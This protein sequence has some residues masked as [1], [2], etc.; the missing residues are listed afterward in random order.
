MSEYMLPMSTESPFADPD[1]E[2]Q[3]QS[4]APKTPGWYP[5]VMDFDGRWEYYVVQ[6]I[7]GEDRHHADFYDPRPVKFL[8]PPEG[9]WD[10]GYVVFKTD[11]RGEILAKYPKNSVD[12]GEG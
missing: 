9:P 6:I 4:E 8:P 5:A 2:P 3:W 1:D 12:G 10:E 7:E 11:E